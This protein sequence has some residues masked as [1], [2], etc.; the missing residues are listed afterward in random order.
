MVTPL[1]RPELEE[2]ERLHKEATPEGWDAVIE[3]NDVGPDDE[4]YW[5]WFDV[6][7]AQIHYSHHNP[8]ERE[9]AQTDALLISKMHGKLP[10]LLES[11]SFA[12]RALELLR[13]M[14]QVAKETDDCPCCATLRVYPNFPNTDNCETEHEPGCALAELLRSLPAEPAKEKPDV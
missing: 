12:E 1:S 14:D 7:P 8:Y 11:A 4:G 5:E 9:L 10:A 6:G 2:L 3:E 13:S